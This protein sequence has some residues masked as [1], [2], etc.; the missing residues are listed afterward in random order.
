MA[1]T[2]DDMTAVYY[3]QEN[4]GLQMLWRLSQILQDELGRKN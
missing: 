2:V 1:I 3:N 4:P